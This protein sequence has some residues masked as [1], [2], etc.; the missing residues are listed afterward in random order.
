MPIPPTLQDNKD[1]RLLSATPA[2]SQSQSIIN[3]EIPSSHPGVLGSFRSGVIASSLDFC[4]QVGLVGLTLDASVNEIEASLFP[5]SGVQQ[6]AKLVSLPTWRG[7]ESTTQRII[8]PKF[9]GDT[10]KISVDVD[11]WASHKHSDFSLE[12]TPFVPAVIERDLAA[13]CEQ[14]AQLAGLRLPIR[15]RLRTENI[16]NGLVGRVTKGNYHKLLRMGVRGYHPDLLAFAVSA[17]SSLLASHVTD[18]IE[19]CRTWESIGERE[20][21]NGSWNRIEE[22]GLPI[23][24]K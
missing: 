6:T 23:V 9:A 12:N 3:Q 19:E 8:L 2:S 17:G 20:E 14:S 16:A 18:V 15:A 7:S 5:A 1:E 10:L 22:A 4:P 24:P 21:E 11:P 13:S